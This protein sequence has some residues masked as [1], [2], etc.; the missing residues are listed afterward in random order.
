MILGSWR[1]VE[2]E[3]NAPA[4]RSGRPASDGLAQ[5]TGFPVCTKTFIHASNH[6][7]TLGVTVSFLITRGGS[8]NEN[9]DERTGQPAA[10]CCCLAPHAARNPTPHP[11]TPP[12]PAP[13][14]RLPTSPGQRAGAR[15]RAAPGVE[16]HFLTADT[17]TP[18]LEGH[19]K[20][21]LEWTTTQGLVHVTAVAAYPTPR[22]PG[23]RPPEAV[24]SGRGRP[25]EP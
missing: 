8:E 15:T 16:P 22:P 2:Q 18:R 19:G 12:N 7:L 14:G 4:G 3:R 23:A 24:G 9:N 11:P 13:R 6:S 5:G 20:E 17:P 1:W 21:T 25:S 10:C